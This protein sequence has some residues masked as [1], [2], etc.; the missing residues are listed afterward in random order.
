M[1]K[2]RKCKCK[3]LSLSLSCMS[4]WQRREA[5]DTESSQ[6]P[7]RSERERRKNEQEKKL[8][9]MGQS[10]LNKQ[11]DSNRDLEGR[12]KVQVNCSLEQRNRKENTLQGHKWR[13]RERER[14]RKETAVTIIC[15]RQ[16]KCYDLQIESTMDNVT[17][18]RRRKR[19]RRAS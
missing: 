15:R 10:E 5:N 9:W 7:A 2:K 4:I 1:Q 11:G 8:S 14:E 18:A 12:A 17:G 3:S 19:Q 13:A 6:I 16:L